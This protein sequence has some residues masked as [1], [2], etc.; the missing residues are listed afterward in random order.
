MTLKHTDRFVEYRGIQNGRAWSRSGASPDV[1][2]L[3]QQG[4][5]LEVCV[6]YQLDWSVNSCLWCST[7][8][9]HANGIPSYF[10]EFWTQSPYYI[11]YYHGQL[12]RTWT[13]FELT[14]CWHVPGILNTGNGHQR[15]RINN[16]T[17]VLTFQPWFMKDIR[18]PWSMSGP[19]YYGYLQ[20]S[21][22]NSQGLYIRIYN[23]HVLEA[24]PSTIQIKVDYWWY[25]I[26]V[27][28]DTQSNCCPRTYWNMIRRAQQ[29]PVQVLILEVPWIPHRRN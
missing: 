8:R 4:R 2:Y 6:Q 29:K 3:L 1:R 23:I 19:F 12:V 21:F 14:T 25:Q 26:S 5:A 17:N 27:C 28:E 18:Y 9:Y 13:K 10:N 7:S 20:L 15:F 24:S 22:I 16:W 11:V